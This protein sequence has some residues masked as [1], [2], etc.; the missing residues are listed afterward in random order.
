VFPLLE[1]HKRLVLALLSL[2]NYRRFDLP[3]LMAREYL[4]TELDLRDLTGAEDRSRWR[5]AGAEDA[6][7]RSS[8]RDIGVPVR[9]VISSQ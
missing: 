1:S 2:P 6:H 8:R 3:P 5:V 4:R 9:G 7:N